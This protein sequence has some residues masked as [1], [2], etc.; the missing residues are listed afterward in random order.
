[1]K[2]VPTKPPATPSTPGR[3]GRQHKHLQHLIKAWAEHQGYRVTLEKP[4]SDG[5]GNVDVVLEGKGSPIETGAWPTLV[6]ASAGS[7][8]SV[9]NDQLD[10]PC[11]ISGHVDAVYVRRPHLGALLRSLVSLEEPM[12]AGPAVVCCARPEGASR[13]AVPPES[14]RALSGGLLAP[15]HD[16]RRQR[17]GRPS[18]SQMTSIMRSASLRTVRHLKSP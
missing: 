3:G 9:L 2:P 11:S 7:Q 4:T 16:L 8:S 5:R 14:S 12:F 6:A 15:R 10:V 13:N 18:G 1:M 17:A